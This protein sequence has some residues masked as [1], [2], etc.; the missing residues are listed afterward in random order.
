[1][2]SE[3]WADET[4]FHEHCW[5]VYPETNKVIKLAE[6]ERMY[7]VQEIPPLLKEGR[8]Y[9][10]FNGQQSQKGCA[11]A[12]QASILPSGA[13]NQMADSPGRRRRPF[14]LPNRRAAP[15]ND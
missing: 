15:I 12:G 4:Y 13:V 9:G 2:L 14:P 6:V 1:M 5:F 11:G 3:K 7:G 8:V 10:Y